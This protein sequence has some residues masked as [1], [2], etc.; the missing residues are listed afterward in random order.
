MSRDE[1][2]KKKDI[3][4]VCYETDG[5]KHEFKVS[6]EIIESIFEI[7]KQKKGVFSIW[8]FYE[9]K[10]ILISE[11]RKNSSLNA[12]MEY[13]V[14][15]TQSPRDRYRGDEA[16]YSIS[17]LMHDQLCI[18]T[19][20]NLIFMTLRNTLP[21]NLDDPIDEFKNTTL[22]VHTQ[23]NRI[24]LVQAIIDAKANI[25]AVN[26]RGDTALITAAFENH[27][28]IMS[29]LIKADANIEAKDQTGRTA[30]I[31]AAFQGHTLA[32]RRLVKYKANRTIK[33]NFGKYA[34]DYAISSGIFD[35]VGLLIDNRIPKDHIIKMVSTLPDSIEKE[36]I[37]LNLPDEKVIAS[38]LTSTSTQTFH[39]P[40]KEL[41]TAQKLIAY[42]KL[43][44]EFSIEAYKKLVET[45][46]RESVINKKTVSD[47]KTALYFSL[48]A[49]KFKRARILI[50]VGEADLNIPTATGDTALK[51]IKRLIKETPI[52]EQQQLKEVVDFLPQ[53]ELSIPDTA[54]PGLIM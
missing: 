21:K 35:T 14:K 36:K 7:E 47:G 40:P 45:A 29:L 48:E 5:E 37:L 1:K 19:I 24:E 31:L 43:K 46:K 8:D 16:N 52:S 39:Q 25:D 4:N 38:K 32:V 30:L 17:D 44:K 53:L 23:N 22:I 28:E 11:I 50:E 27:L 41:K 6:V 54:G 2:D 15:K 51:L 26:Y 12:L 13:Y 9:I 42:S 20:K 18:N 3:I 33:D 49:R 10:I 34:F